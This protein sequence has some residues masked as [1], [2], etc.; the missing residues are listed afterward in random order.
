MAFLG[1]FFDSVLDWFRSLFWSQEM[2]LTLVGLGG[3]GK[4]TLVN[5]I[6]TGQFNEDMIPTVG[7]SMK[8]VKRG[9]VEIKLWDIGGQVRFRSMWERYCRDVNAIVFVVDAA[10]PELFESARK[11]LD[12]LVK[13]PQVQGIPL[14][15]LCNKN[16]LKEAVDAKEVVDILEFNKITDRDTMYYSISAKENVNIE[17]VL[18][19]LIKYAGNSKD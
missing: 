19:W 15:L 11:E 4:T 14:L 13:K 18:D 5:L 1:E 8:K 6:S 12:G 17:K 10:A 16:D 9:N 7:F 2:E 3:S